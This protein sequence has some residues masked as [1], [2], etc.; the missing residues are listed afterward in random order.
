MPVLFAGALFEEGGN[1]GVAFV[2]DLSE[3]E[4]RRGSP[5]GAMKS[6]L[7]EAQRLSTDSGTSACRPS[8]P[9]EIYLELGRNFPIYGY[10]PIYQTPRSELDCSPT[11]SS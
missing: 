6:Y 9:D 1:E 7:T 5:Y 2:L 8:H 3:A 11:S 4:A 10:D